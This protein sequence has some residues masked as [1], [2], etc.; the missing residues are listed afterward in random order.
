MY[1]DSWYS[2]VPDVAKK[3]ASA[4]QGSGHRRKESLLQ[5]PNVSPRCFHPTSL[6]TAF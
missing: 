4:A 6:W 2:F 3:A 5:Q 1:D